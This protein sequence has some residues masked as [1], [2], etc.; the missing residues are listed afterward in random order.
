M[1]FV[2]KKDMNFKGWRWNGMVCLC[3][4][5]SCIEMLIPNMII[6]GCRALERCLHHDSG[7][8]MHGISVFIKGPR[9]LP[10]SFY[11]G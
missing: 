10:C 8:L 5:N 6:L 9:E 11:H 4:P 1:Y 2:F 3:P 7:V